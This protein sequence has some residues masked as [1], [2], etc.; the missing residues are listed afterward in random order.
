MTVS[1]DQHQI[2]IQHNLKR[3]NSKPLLREIY[4][5]FYEKLVSHVDPK[6]PGPVV[7]VGSGIGN[8]KSSLP[9]AITTDLFPNPWLD[10]VCDAYDL[11]FESG[12]ISHVVMFDVFHHLR[13]PAAVLREVKRVLT[14]FGRLI[15]FDPYI[16]LCSFPIYGLL[17]HEPI[18]W[19]QPIDLTEVQPGSNDYYAAQGNATRL[20]FKNEA[21]DWPPGWALLHAEAFSCF[22]YLLSGG[23]SKPT[24]YPRACLSKVQW[25]DRILSC[26]PSV[27]GGRCVVVLQ[28]SSKV[29]GKGTKSV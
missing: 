10:Q 26:W 2:E 5:G 18:A 29:A 21:P 1:L 27:F 28:N 11:P 25:M 6:L 7:E 13:C 4:A 19:R 17:H 22:H 23:Y 24:L 12:T 20:F 14:E 16:S 3:W 9:E 15:I 8:I